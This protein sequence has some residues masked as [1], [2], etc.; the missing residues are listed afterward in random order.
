MDLRPSFENIF[1]NL[2]KQ[3]SL[4]SHCVRKKVGAV[5]VRDNRIISVG[6]NGPPAGTYNCDEKWPEKG[7][8]PQSNG[9]CSLAVHAEENA[10]IYASKNGSNLENATIYITLSPC[11]SCARIIF[12]VGI[13][14]VI[15]VDKYSDYKSNTKEEGIKFLEMFGVVVQQSKVLSSE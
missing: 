14:K 7:C 12:S 11:L 4:R 5:L 2:A 10:I 3:L 15:Y 8:Y 13:K 1:L 9:G 6:Y